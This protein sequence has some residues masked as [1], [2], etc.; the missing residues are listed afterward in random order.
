MAGQHGPVN[1]VSSGCEHSLASGSFSYAS[2]ICVFFLEKLDF[3]PIRRLPVAQR[4]T[5]NARPPARVQL[6]G[7]RFPGGEYLYSILAWR[8]P[9]AR[10]WRGVAKSQASSGQQHRFF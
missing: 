2:I 7:G 1:H 9:W 6:L 4:S 8:N 5:C 10:V 3:A